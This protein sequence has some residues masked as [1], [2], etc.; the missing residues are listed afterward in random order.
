VIISFKYKFI[1]IKNYKAAGSSIETYLYNF[2]NHKDIVAQTKDYQGINH[3]FEF[4]SK[5]LT[6]NFEKKYQDK[7]IKNKM[8][9]FAHM[10]AWLIKERIGNDIFDKFFKFCVIR[11]PWDV[12]VSHY[13]WINS[14]ENINKDPASFKKVI[15]DLQ[16]EYIDSHNIFNYYKI[17]ELKNK[18]NIMVDTVCCFENLNIELQKIF[19]FLNIP[20]D[21]KLEIFKKVSKAKL[22]Y[23]KYYDEESKKIIAKKFSNEIDLMG[24]SF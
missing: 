4:N 10:P 17:C 23:Q 24:Y 1:F 19:N 16:N 22:P 3:R 2:L 12:V 18:K 9:Y 11:N 7:Y 20:F 13:H 5:S 14:K 21:G 8:A 15:Y 6:E